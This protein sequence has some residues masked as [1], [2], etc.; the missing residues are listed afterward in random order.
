MRAILTAE[1]P[2]LPGVCQSRGS[3]CGGQTQEGGLCCLACSPVTPELKGQT[4]S[5][6]SA[7]GAEVGV[8]SARPGLLSSP[9][10]V[11]PL[12]S[13]CRRAISRGSG[14]EGLWGARQPS[15]RPLSSLP[16]LFLDLSHLLQTEP[17]GWTVGHPSTQVPR[18]CSQPSPSVPAR[19]PLQ[20]KPSSHGWEEGY[21]T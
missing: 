1:W 14:R 6:A 20:N 12:Q 9:P 19:S 5:R 2:C 17:A 21:R 3:R 13:W 4:H 10:P 15:L 7:V 8:V 11:R 18:A 16:T